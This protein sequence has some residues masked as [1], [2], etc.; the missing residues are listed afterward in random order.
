M[1]YPLLRPFV[2]AKVKA[3][4][5][6]PVTPDRRCR[7]SCSR[8]SVLAGRSQLRIRKRQCNFFFFP[9]LLNCREQLVGQFVL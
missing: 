4:E 3:T 5:N 6:I 9:Q 1:E 2:I 8:S 7:D